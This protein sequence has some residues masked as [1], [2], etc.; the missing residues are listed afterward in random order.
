MN[1]RARGLLLVMVLAA[2]TAVVLTGGAARSSASTT[3]ACSDGRPFCV[4]VEDLDQRSLSTVSAHYMFYKVT[5]TRKADGGRSNL[6]NGTLTLTLTDIIGVD[7][8]LPGRPTDDPNDVPSTAVF[9]PSPVST[10]KCSVG[11]SSNVLTCTVSNFPAGADPQSYEPL[12]FKTSTTANAASTKL[13]AS[14]RFK[15]K[16]NDNQPSDPNQDTLAV[17]EYTTYEPDP[18]LDVS[19]AYPNASIVLQTSTVDTP[20]ND[21]YST[22][23]LVIPSAHAPFT[24]SLQETPV[25]PGVGFCGNCKG[26]VA[27]TFGGGIFSASKPAHVTLVWDFKPS[28]FTEN[29]GTAY[30]QPDSGPTEVI[31]TKCTFAPNATTPSVLPCRTITIQNLGRGKVK[32]TTDI[33]SN[34][35]GGW[36]VG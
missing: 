13:A 17:A 27:Q 31:T 23:P 24:A 3:S 10:S 29:G 14:A 30:H 34:D 11:S 22:F 18:N 28:G 32:V 6:T 25:T 4:T 20:A 12:I 19:W 26:E 5:I 8:T 35:N 15:E 16:G 7:D 36:G 2:A 9:Q 1:A 21:Q 33:W